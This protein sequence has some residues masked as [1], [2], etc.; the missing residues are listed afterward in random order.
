MH[1]DE[2]VIAPVSQAAAWDFL[3]QI[4]RVAACLPGC[5][6]V[7]QVTPGTQYRARM[8][9]AIGPYRVGMDLDVTVEEQRAPEYLRVGARG[10]DARL[11]VTQTMA[12]DLRL[13]PQGPD[14][15]VLD[16]AADV[17]VGGALGMLGGFVLRRKAK[18][19][20][21]QFA[22]NLQAALRAT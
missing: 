2:R 7:Q 5:R 21:E 22:R 1:F 10:Q 16:I 3:W 14:R 4:E 6:A 18:A 12:L 11:G 20:V 13:T 8:E 19:I 15:T 17:E 9:D